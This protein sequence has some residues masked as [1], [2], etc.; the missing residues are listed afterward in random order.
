LLGGDASVQNDYSE[1]LPNSIS[2]HVGIDTIGGQKANSTMPPIAGVTIQLRDASGTVIG[3]ATTDANGNYQFTD[4]TPGTYGVH[5]IQPAGYFDGDTE[6]GSQGG[7]VADDLITNIAL[8]SGVNATDYDFSELLP[9]S[10]AGHVGVDTVG[11]Q[12]ANSSMPPISGVT[13]QLLDLSGNVIGTTTTDANG[14]YSF[15]GMAPKT[16]GIHEVQPAGYLDGDTEA[17]SKGGTVTDDSITK[18]VL[19]SGIHAT[20][21]DFSELLPDSIGGHVGIA[22]EGECGTNLTP[23]IANVVIHLL[24]SSGNVIGTTTTDANGNYIFDNLRFGTYGIL[25]DEPAGYFHADTH[26]GAAGGTVAGNLISSIV[27]APG[28]DATDYDYC[29]LL[30]VSIA[31]HVGVDTVGGQKANSSMPPISGVTIQLLDSSGNVIGTTTTDA[32]GNYSFSGMPPKTYGIH[33]VQPAEYL[34]GDTEAGSQGGTVTDDSITKIV[35]TSGIHA[36]DYDFSE[37]LPV[38]IAGYVFQDGPPIHVENAG[39]V[40]DVLAL[41]DGKLTP[42][43]TLLP[44]VTLELRDGVTGQPILG[45]AALPGLYAANQP[46]T[47]VT[48][49][50]GHYQ[51]NGLAPGVYGVFDIKPAGYLSG[52]DTP[53]STGGVLVSA[54]IVTD[55][56]V[57]AQLTS[58]PVDD[59]ILGVNLPVGQNSINNNFSVVVTATGIQPFVFPQTPGATPLVVPPVAIPFV[60]LTPPPVPTLPFYLAPQIRQVG[61]AMFTWHLSVV[62]A[63]QPRQVRPDS[64]ARLMSV[65]PDDDVLNGYDLENGDWTLAPDDAGEAPLKGR[66]LRFGIRGGI[67]IAGDFDGDGKWEVGVFKDGRW[68]IDLNNNGVWDAGDLWAKL[69]TRN[70]MPVTGDWDGDGKTD[71]GIYGPAWSGDPRAVA[72]E[73]GIPDPNNE[74]TGV[75]KNIPRQPEQTSKGQREMKLTSEGKARADLIDHVFFYGTPGD[76]PVAGDWNGDGTHTVAVFRNGVWWRD[77]NGDGKRN[78]SDKPTYFGQPGDMPVV[79]DFNGDGIDELGVYRDG[80]WYIDTNANGVID[81]EDTVFQLGGPGD[82]PVVGD[83]NGDGK[84][85]PGVYHDAPPASAKASKD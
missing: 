5:E 67:P 73:P 29:E 13:I 4:L 55:P 6:A 54:L 80:T 3:T 76:R 17:G 45:S 12:K 71:I 65:Q 52:I 70:D 72:H 79:G 61:G 81:A 41:R 63:G 7:T 68:F 31:G 25:E 36:T 2:G 40:P 20:D 37:L 66:R 85:E 33:E 44:G 23:P 34:D 56:A 1:A 19:T 74:N 38:S 10:I 64:V 21:Y 51:F 75:H 46:I 35:L 84:A 82:R 42:D 18:I 69:G 50:N 47:T 28:I 16:Y 62:D 9:V 83:W 8:L 53:G 58:K 78:H 22:V 30:P 26:A 32:N 57:L 24:D 59:A 48:D 14:N 15:A 60:Q 11:G 77:T 49:A 43:D 39:D 27:L